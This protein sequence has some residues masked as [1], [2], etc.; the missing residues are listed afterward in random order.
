MKSTKQEPYVEKFRVCYT[1]LT[2]RDGPMTDVP[3]TDFYDFELYNRTEY[4]N[5]GGKFATILRELQAM[6]DRKQADYGSDEDPF[7]NIRASR[8][9]GLKPWVGAM[10]RANDKVKRLQSAARGSELKNEGIED[11]LI[12]I[13]VYTIIALSLFREEQEEEL[14]EH[15]TGQLP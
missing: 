15:T 14:N 3:M 9:F 13:A 7:A 5:R 1:P 8:E 2:V 4:R 10:L 11:S 6:H 12:D